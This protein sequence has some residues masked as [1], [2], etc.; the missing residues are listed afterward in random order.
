ML[1]FSINAHVPPVSAPPHTQEKGREFA[2]AL[3]LA[4]INAEGNPRCLPCANPLPRT[5][6][7]KLCPAHEEDGQRDPARVF[8][9][10]C[11]DDLCQINT[12]SQQH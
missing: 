12:V 4:P 9:S 6:G 11:R 3:R 2:M 7:R 5:R 1:Q 10:H 8:S